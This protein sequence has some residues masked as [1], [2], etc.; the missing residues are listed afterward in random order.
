MQLHDKEGTIF[1]NKDGT[2]SGEFMVHG[3]V[4]KVRGE[5]AM[6]ATGKTYMQ[7]RAVEKALTEV[8]PASPPRTSVSRKL[9]LVRGM[10]NVEA[11]HGPGSRLDPNWKQK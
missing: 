1:L 5:V 7:L 9:K 3:V 4:F 6:S 8:R 11:M 10:A 2:W